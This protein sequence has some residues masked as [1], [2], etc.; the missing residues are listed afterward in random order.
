MNKMNKMNSQIKAKAKAK[1][2]TSRIL[3]VDI[4]NST[5]RLAIMEN[6]QVLEKHSHPTDKSK[7]I[8]QTLAKL[9]QGLTGQ[10][11]KLVVISSVVSSALQDLE[12]FLAQQFD[13]QALVIGKN[14]PLPM[15]LDLP[16]ADTVG[17]DRIVCAAMAY[18]RVEEAVAVADFG[19]AITIDCVDDQGLFLGGTI[20]PGLDIAAAALAEHTAAL[21]KVKLANPKGIFGKDTVQ[22]IRNG[23]VYGAVGAMREI[24]ERFATELHKWPKLMLTG[25]QAELIAEHC[26]FVDAVVPDLS[27]MGIELAFGKWL[28]EQGR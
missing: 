17:T 16:N 22:A 10:A 2:K 13:I 27:L 19:T 6:Q 12:K 26:Q 3:A 9:V 14:L 20:L 11:A 5:T 8:S 24:V 21:P 23:L 4:G 18:Q 15:Q 25:G 7:S 1:T 28:T